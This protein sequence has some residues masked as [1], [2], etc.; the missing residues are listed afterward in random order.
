M[1]SSQIG[2]VF[3]LENLV[4]VHVWGDRATGGGQYSSLSTL[5]GAQF[6]EEAN[7]ISLIFGISRF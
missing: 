1:N 5:L 6:Q 3:Q 4:L 2:G 7:E